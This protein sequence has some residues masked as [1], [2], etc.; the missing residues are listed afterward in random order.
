MD[1]D[2]IRAP[3]DMVLIEIQDVAALR[4]TARRSSGNESVFLSDLTT[5]SFLLVT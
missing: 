4:A 1:T 2:T 3:T 5:P